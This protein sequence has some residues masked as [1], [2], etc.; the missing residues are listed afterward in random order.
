MTDMVFYRGYHPLPGAR[1][2][3][4]GFEILFAIPGNPKRNY[5]LEK[6]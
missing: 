2:P 1:T 5:F 4:G 3:K 6:W